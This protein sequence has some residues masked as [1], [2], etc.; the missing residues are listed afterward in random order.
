MSVFEELNDKMNDGIEELNAHISNMPSDL[1]KQIESVDLT[2]ANSMVK[3]AVA[4]AEQIAA[5]NIEQLPS[6]PQNN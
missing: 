6:G 2:Q 4:A 5:T 1:L 3:N